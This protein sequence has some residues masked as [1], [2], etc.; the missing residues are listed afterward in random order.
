MTICT[1]DRGWHWRC[2][3]AECLLRLSAAA[4]LLWSGLWVWLLCI[5][6]ICFTLI[7]FWYLDSVA[8][9]HTCHVWDFHACTSPPLSYDLSWKSWNNL[10]SWWLVLCNCFVHVCFV[11]QM[12]SYIFLIDGIWLLSVG[13][14]HCV[15][16]RVRLFLLCLS[17]FYIRDHTHS[18]WLTASVRACRNQNNG[19][20]RST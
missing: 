6:H 11:L 19:G 1:A 17:L 8:S 4:V 18:V 5:G 12:I 14:P 13:F 2:L 10:L 3:H 20:Q 7:R 9:L 16:T 15:C